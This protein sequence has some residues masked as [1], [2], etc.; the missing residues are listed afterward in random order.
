M[1]LLTNLE[2][3]L[4]QE[5]NKEQFQAAMLMDGPA[6]VMAGAGSGKTYTLISRVVHL[7]DSGVHP[8]QILM[9]TFTNKAADEMKERAAKK[10]ADSGAIMACTYHS[11]S[12]KLLQRYHN[13]LQLSACQP[14]MTTAYNTLIDLMRN[15][16]SFFESMKS[17]KTKTIAEIYSKSINKMESIESIVQSE[18]CYADCLQHVMGLETLK[19]TMDVKKRHDGVLTYDDMLF[20]VDELMGNEQIVR[21]IAT[22]FKYIMVD[23][24]QD[25]NNLQESFILKLARYNPNIVV[26]GDI[27]QSIYA[28]RGANVENIQTFGDKLNCMGYHCKDIILHQN[29]R[30]SQEILDLANI[31]MQNNV[32]GWRYHNM[33]SGTK[34]H[35]H[36][37]YIVSIDTQKTE[38]QYVMN[39]IQ[40]YHNNGVAY[41]DM[42]VLARGSKAF[43][44]LEYLL[45]KSNISYEK[46]GGQKFFERDCI[47][48]IFDYFRFLLNNRN[49]SALYHILQIHPNIGGCTASDLS[50]NIA[51]GW[52][53]LLDAKLH[54]HRKNRS[55]ELKPVPPSVKMQTEQ[56]VN[57]Y[58]RLED[59]PNFHKQFRMIAD[60]YERTMENAITT[61]N[62]KED[63]K[64]ESIEDLRNSMKYI[65]QL[66]ELSKSYD[67]A[68]KFVDEMTLNL[69]E[70]ANFNGDNLVLS[71]VHSAK[72]LEWKVVF[73]LDCVEGAFPSHINLVD[74]GSEEDME[75]LRCFYVAMTRAKDDLYLMSPS[76]LMINGQF[77]SVNMSHYLA[78]TL[79]NLNQQQCDDLFEM[80]NYR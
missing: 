43:Q 18:D 71:T 17:I 37:P 58:E 49:E 56:L 61:S 47:Q 10:V 57:L 35:G 76:M 42:A 12:Y 59:E 4:W 6:V 79:N 80:I 39:M 65:M 62:M 27:S 21:T 52:C 70:D 20:Y 64:N 8:S 2:L 50:G 45:G 16:N 13:V 46:R 32:K 31:V 44:N 30:S 5:L 11:F 29:Y 78:N 34:K 23:E 19:A 75:E 40:N 36:K 22:Q 7:I 54:A 72:G 9:L 73:I 28:F 66:E 1:R 14:I 51:E 24:F 63:N 3:Q 60:F 53:T 25:T 74:Y 69:E 15:R 68:Q 67:D 48:M 33:I 26:V 55:G 41:S 38:A 77:Q